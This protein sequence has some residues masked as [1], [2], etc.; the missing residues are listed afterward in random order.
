MRIKA[1]NLW[2]YCYLKKSSKIRWGLCLEPISIFVNN[3]GFVLTI[4]N[5]RICLER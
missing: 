2:K 3:H 5:I 4:L 1:T